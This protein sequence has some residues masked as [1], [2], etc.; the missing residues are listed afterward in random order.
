[1]STVTNISNGGAEAELSRCQQMLSVVLFITRLAEKA[2]YYYTLMQCQAATG[3]YNKPTA[4]VRLIPRLF[5]PVHWT[6]SWDPAYIEMLHQSSLLSS[7]TAGSDWPDFSPYSSLHPNALM[8]T[9]VCVCVQACM[10]VSWK[11]KKAS[12]LVPPLLPLASYSTERKTVGL[13][14]HFRLFRLLEGCLSDCLW[15]WGERATVPVLTILASSH[16]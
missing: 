3:A 6:T 8:F 10:W 14:V 13:Q 12:R 2:L 15:I 5:G 9:C 7:N 1:M 11:R 16:E 4:L